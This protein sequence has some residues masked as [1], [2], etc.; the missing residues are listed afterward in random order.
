MGLDNPA[1]VFPYDVDQEVIILRDKIDGRKVDIDYKDT[2][3][4]E[5][6]RANLRQINEWKSKL[7]VIEEGLVKRDLFVCSPNTL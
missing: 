1:F 7:E 6:F 4:T 2:P 5:R 3:K